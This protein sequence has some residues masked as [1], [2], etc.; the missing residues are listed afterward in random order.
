MLMNCGSLK[1]SDEALMWDIA[2]CKRG[3]TRLVPGKPTPKGIDPV[4]VL[5]LFLGIEV[6]G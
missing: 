3:N 2:G 5:R 4:C 1:A 6:Y